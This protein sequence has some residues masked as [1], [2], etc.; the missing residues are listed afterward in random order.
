[1]KADPKIIVAIRK[2]P[3]TKK[4]LSRSEQDIVDVVSE[5][6]LAVKELRQKVDLT[7][8]IEEH[9]FTFDAVF[10]DKQPNEELYQQLVR[11]LVAS[12]FDR[13]KI[14]CFA[15]GQT[16]SGKTYTMMGNIEAGVPGLYL[17]AASDIFALLSNQEFSGLIVGISFYEIYCDKAHDLLNSREKCPIRVD[18]KE[19]VNIVGLTEKII[20]NTESLMALIH[21]GLSVRITGSTGMNDDSSRSHAILQITL[22]N[23]Q[24]GKVHGR[25][26]FID[27][28]GSERGADVTDTN[29]QTRFDGA[30]INKSLLALKECIRALDLDKRHLPFRASKLTLVLKD[31]FIGNCKTLMIGNISPAINSC[32][33]TLNTLRYADRVKE[34][35]KAPGSTGAVKEKNLEDERAR[36][37]MLPRMKQNANRI[38][39][40]TQKTA[41]DNIV[42][43]SFDVNAQLKNKISNDPMRQQNLLNKANTKR[44][45]MS[46]DANISSYRSTANPNQFQNPSSRLTTDNFEFQANKGFPDFSDSHRKMRD[47]KRSLTPRSKIH[48]DNQGSKNNVRISNDVSMNLQANNNFMRGPSPPVPKERSVQDPHEFFNRHNYEQDPYHRRTHQPTAQSINSEI[49]SQQNQRLFFGQHSNNFL[50]QNRVPD[51]EPQPLQ[52]LNNS[53]DRE[54]MSKNMA[55][56]TI[57]AEPPKTQNNGMQIEYSDSKNHPAH[58]RPTGIRRYPEI[59]YETLERISQQQDDLIEEHSYQIDELVGC[60]KEDMSILQNARDTRKLTSHRHRRVPPQNQSADQTEAPNHPPFRSEASQLRKCFQSAGCHESFGRTRFQ[61]RT[62]R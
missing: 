44:G 24:N 8:F 37:L 61:C 49:G 25:M 2:R 14:T 17:L 35:K 51:N 9:L 36:I 22:R 32:E 52:Q 30:E 60:V 12:A 43:E 41:D 10:S 56:V 26:S 19:N 40:N 18:A 7:K 54:A 50:G 62:A 15:Y 42:F 23:K 4:E 46:M 31:S 16:G 53:S 20:A 21:Y 29:K 13:A 39:L 28:A 3:L 58:L 33:H 11:P 27:L 6:T 38:T 57:V 59:N 5:D 45:V 55:Q 47:A 34:L 1:M 48:L